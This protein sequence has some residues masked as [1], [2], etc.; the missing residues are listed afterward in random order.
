MGL[1]AE[2]ALGFCM[3][4]VNDSRYYYALPPVT[5]YGLDCS[6]FVIEAWSTGDVNYPGANVPVHGATDTSNMIP[7]MTT[8]GTFTR[9]N[10]D[11]NFALRGDIFL[12]D[13]PTPGSTGGHTCI[14]L[15]NNQIVHAANSQTGIV[16]APYNPSAGFTDILRY[17]DTP[18]VPQ[19]HAKNQ[20]GYNRDSTEAI[21]N[22]YMIYSI[23]SSYGW[24]L[25][26]VCGFLGNVGFESAY[27]PW[28]WEN[29]IVLASTD[30]Y[31]IDIATNHGYGLCQFTPAGKYISDPRAQ[32]MTGYAPNF[33]DIPG[34]LTDG[35]AQLWFIDQYADYLPTP[36]YPQT[37]ADFKAW[38]GSAED[39][40]SIWIHN[41][42]RP[43]VYTTEPQRRDEAHYWFGVL[44]GYNPHG[45][46]RGLPPW[47]INKLIR[48]EI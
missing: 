2:M 21:E 3:S 38:T 19:W 15:G 28:R 16:V 25:P 23:L 7:C 18:F 22:A 12:W 27:N 45:G 4:I 33:S 13:D 35:S 41:Y 46:N 24:T 20:L 39:A 1:R 31:N 48:K 11:I 26:A 17:N 29:D 32:I 42:E 6:T 44:Q 37:Y 14:Y 5:P 40:A 43:L 10:F 9:Y 8:N 47:F 30:T 36:S 34:A